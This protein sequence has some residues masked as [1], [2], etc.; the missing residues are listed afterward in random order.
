MNSYRKVGEILV[1]MPD[2]SI[3]PDPITCILWKHGLNKA[4]EWDKDFGLYTYG[5][6]ES[7]TTLDQ[8][9]GELRITSLTKQTMEFILWSLTAYCLTRHIHYLISK[10]VCICVRYVRVCMLVPLLAVCVCVCVSSN[11]P[12]LSL[13]LSWI[14]RGSPKT[15]N[16]FFL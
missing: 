12:A 15:Q 13:F 1:L 5:G 14:Y 6:F 9:T 11:F 7:G 16:H 4:A 2:K 8:A 3:I 10:R